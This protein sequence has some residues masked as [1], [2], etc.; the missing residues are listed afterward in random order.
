ML[1]AQE[2]LS[3]KSSDLPLWTLGDETE[4]HYAR[5][6]VN[7]QIC[8]KDQMLHQERPIPVPSAGPGR[9]RLI[10]FFLG[11]IASLAAC[12]GGHNSTSVPPVTAPAP[13][14]PNATP[15]PAAPN[16]TPTPAATLPPTALVYVSN[17]GQAAAT[18]NA[19]IVAFPL[20]TGGNIS[21]VKT[22][23]G[24]ATQLITPNVLMF[25]SNGSLYVANESNPYNNPYGSYITVYPP[26]SNGNVAPSRIIRGGNANFSGLGLTAMAVDG[27]GYLYVSEDTSSENCTSTSSSSCTATANDTIL[28]F[29]PGANGNVAPVRTINSSSCFE[30]GGLAVLPS[31]DLAAACMPPS[32]PVAP[33][34][35]HRGRATAASAG[36]MD[37]SQNIAEIVTFADG[38]SGNATP[39]NVITGSNT[40]M[41]WAG[42][43]ALSPQGTL[44]VAPQSPSE[45]NPSILGFPDSA[46]GNVAPLL[47]ISGSQTELNVIALAVDSSGTIYALNSTNGSGTLTI[48]EYPGSANGNVAPAYTIAGSNT[49]LTCPQGSSV[50]AG[51]IAIGPP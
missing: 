19:T 18:G 51:G 34:S 32:Y 8:S 33:Y 5:H 30:I 22:I 23:A 3:E 4:G 12:S 47:N 50:C 28:V 24:N 41:S 15:T 27:N 49:T 16:T 42:A 38:A 7:Q 13:A 21:P 6:A 31:N 1:A 25:D 37:A 20:G 35:I 9:K 29:A 36:P 10:I 40:E 46:S 11:A 44:L 14:G 39:I 26:G 45:V 43:L 17:T 2:D 48:T